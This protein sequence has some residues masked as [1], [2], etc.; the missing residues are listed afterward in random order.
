[1]RE[2][3]EKKKVK[4]VAK[5]KVVLLLLAFFIFILTTSSIDLYKKRERVLKIKS[6][7][8]R[9]LKVTLTEKSN[10]TEEIKKLKS[11]YGVE[12]LMR[13]KYNAVWEGEGVIVVVDK[14]IT[15]ESFV[16]KEGFFE[17]LKRKIMNLFFSEKNL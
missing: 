15:K 2:F 16:K 4:N 3:Q 13:E 10:L 11:P 12:K 6:D 5:S 1:M 17:S 9:E 14:E 8:D 7:L